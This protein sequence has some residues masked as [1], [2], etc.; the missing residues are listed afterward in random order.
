MDDNTFKALSLGIGAVSTVGLSA[1]TYLTLVANHKVKEVK[2]TL[3]A[4]T[5]ST[6]EKLG[7][8]ASAAEDSKRV[9]N[10]IHTLVNAN[11]GAQLSISAV[12][13]RRIADLTKDP[14]DIAMAD[15]A[16]RLLE[17]HTA[18]QDIVDSKDQLTPTNPKP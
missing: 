11:M 12:A 4:V 13:L 9:G 14:G 3:A 17:E 2:E 5:A 6:D 15:R 10:A 16:Q 8:L 18:Q 1:I 7:S